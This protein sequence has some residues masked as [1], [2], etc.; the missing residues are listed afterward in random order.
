MQLLWRKVIQNNYDFNVLR[1][2]E[3]A[4]LKKKLAEIIGTFYREE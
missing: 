2:R 4:K 3:R 1:P